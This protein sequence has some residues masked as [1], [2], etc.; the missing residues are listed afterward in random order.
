M[1]ISFA[2]VINTCNNL[3]F[4]WTQRCAIKNII[5]EKQST[6][7]FDNSISVNPKVTNHLAEQEGSEFNVDLH[8]LHVLNCTYCELCVGIKECRNGNGAN[9]KGCAQVGFDSHGLVKC[10]DWATVSKLTTTGGSG[11]LL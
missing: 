10:T 5:L 9:Y 3:L 6:H 1:L 4:T 7:K 8:S 2:Y 11:S